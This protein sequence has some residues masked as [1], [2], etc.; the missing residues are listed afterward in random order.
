MKSTI[1]TIGTVVTDENNSH[2]LLDWIMEPPAMLTS[3]DGVLLFGGYTIAEL[4][5]IE[6]NGLS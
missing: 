1:T 5:D 6:A 2:Q 3:V 4:Q